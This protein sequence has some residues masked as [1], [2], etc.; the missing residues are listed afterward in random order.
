M[1]EYFCT[2]YIEHILQ[3]SFGYPPPRGTH[4]GQQGVIVCDGFGTHLCFT[5]IEKAI[6]LGMEI[7]LRVLNL[8][9]V[10]QRE[11]TVNFK[12]SYTR[13]FYDRCYCCC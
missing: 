2:D 8:S 1:N 9:L 7:L 6:E 11:D 10:L 3:P 12:V 5:L 4:P 13:I